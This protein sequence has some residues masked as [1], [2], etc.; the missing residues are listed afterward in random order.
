MDKRDEPF[1]VTALIL[2]LH[3]PDITPDFEALHY[4]IGAAKAAGSLSDELLQECREVECIV[5]G[6]IVCPHG[7]LLHFH[8]DGC[9]S[10]TFE[11]DRGPSI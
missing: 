2:S 4:R 5:C 1:D 6:A 11:E 9:P 3:M 8:H 7:D 10:C